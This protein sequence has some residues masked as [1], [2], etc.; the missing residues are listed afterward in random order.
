[1]LGHGQSTN[2]QKTEQNN[3]HQPHI[4][5][6]LEWLQ[7]FNNPINNRIRVDFKKI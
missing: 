3:T 1:M 5:I 6:K 2:T 7:A 4:Q